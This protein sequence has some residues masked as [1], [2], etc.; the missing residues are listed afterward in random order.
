MRISCDNNAC[1]KIIPTGYCVYSG[2]AQK[3]GR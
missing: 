3:S 2:P 1:F